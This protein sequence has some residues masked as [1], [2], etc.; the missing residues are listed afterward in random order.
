MR[1]IFQNTNLCREHVRIQRK[2]NGGSQLWKY[3]A[4]SRLTPV[5]TFR[6]L[7]FPVWLLWVPPSFSS[8]VLP[9]LPPRFAHSL[10]RQK[11]RRR[12]GERCI[13]KDRFL[14]RN[15]R[16]FRRRRGK[17]G[18]GTKTKTALRAFCRPKRRGGL[19]ARTL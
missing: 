17:K 1:R 14:S 2:T 9:R 12:G 6:F 10:K 13:H 8:F 7:R 18:R 4:R 11:G 5:L 16:K 19:I 15:L 3:A